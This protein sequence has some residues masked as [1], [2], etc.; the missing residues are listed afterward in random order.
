MKRA[1][2]DLAHVKNYSPISIHA[3]VKRATNSGKPLVY[4]HDNFNPRPREEGDSRLRFSW[5]DPVYF[6][7]RPREE[8]DA[9]TAFEMQLKQFISIHA[10]VKRATLIQVLYQQLWEFQSTPS[11]RGRLATGKIA[12]SASTDFN[13]RPREEGDGSVNRWL[14]F[15][16]IFQSTP[17]WRGRPKD[18]FISSDYKTNFN[19]R[20]REEGDRHKN[21]LRHF[22]C[23]FQSTPSWRGR[24]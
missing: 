14:I 20:P 24:L 13:P 9:L 8:G 17:S 23:G 1:T 15:R 10:L 18:E 3:L 2:I 5:R 6:N 22:C 4:S 19:P 16:L 11:W 12:Q 21:W 7:P